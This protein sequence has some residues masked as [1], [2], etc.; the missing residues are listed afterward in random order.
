MVHV[1]NPSSK[2]EP[3]VTQLEKNKILNNTRMVYPLRDNTPQRL[4][5]VDDKAKT[6]TLSQYTIIKCTV[7]TK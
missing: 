3:L 5:C 2:K 4:P 7:Y 1:L 6:Y